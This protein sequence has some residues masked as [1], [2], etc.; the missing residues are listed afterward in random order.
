MIKSCPKIIKTKT[1]VGNSVP[2]ASISGERNALS[3][4]QEV[5]SVTCIRRRRA[6]TQSDDDPGKRAH[7][8]DELS[9]AVDRKHVV[10]SEFPRWS[11]FFRLCISR[12]LQSQRPQTGQ[13]VSHPATYSLLIPAEVQS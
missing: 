5:D 11:L 6:A 12:A 8:T 9:V 10:P 4:R 3:R 7:D 1:D 2:P 13:S